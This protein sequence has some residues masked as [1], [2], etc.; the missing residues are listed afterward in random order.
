MLLHNRKVNKAHEAWQ[1]TPLLLHCRYTII[2]IIMN[3]LALPILKQLGDSSLGLVKGQ[4]T[5]V[6]LCLWLLCVYSGGVGRTGTYL[7]IDMALSQILK[8]LVAILSHIVSTV[9]VYLLNLSFSQEL[10]NLTWQ[11]RWSI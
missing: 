5:N 11:L 4:Q 9:F 6:I 3:W 1:H 2:F 10:R 7:L 8:G